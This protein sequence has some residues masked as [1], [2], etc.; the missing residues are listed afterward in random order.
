[1]KKYYFIIIFILLG[2]FLPIS[3]YVELNHL[4]IVDKI[5]LKCNKD[6]YHLYLR[7]V[8]PKRSDNGIL[9]HYKIYDGTGSNILN[10]YQDLSHHTGKNIY[11][12]K[13]QSLVT[14]CYDSSTTINFFS[15]YPKNIYHTKKNIKK[16]LEKNI[17][18]S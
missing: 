2:F 5:G 13:V 10:A 7:E 17:S 15:I 8:I 4:M 18:N 6:S 9:Y 3:D 1:M 12:K 14:N 16:E 11:I